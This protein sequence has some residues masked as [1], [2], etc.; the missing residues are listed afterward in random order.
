M[1]SIIKRKV[2]IS[3]LFI[4]LVLMGIFSNQYLPMELYP[5]AELP[6]LS[7]GIS[8][9]GKELDPTYVE[10]KAAI[11]VEGVISS[12]EGVE[13]I[14]TTVDPRQTRIR[15]S[16][17][18]NVNIK[19]TQLQL[20][21]KVLAISKTLPEDEFRVTVS[22]GGAGNAGSNQLMNLRILGDDLDYVRNVV[23]V[24]IVPYFEYIDGVAEVAVSGGR[25][26][27][28]EIIVDPD[29]LKALNITKSTI[30][31][32]ISQNQTDKT[33]S[34]TAYDNDKRY[35]VNV[36][37]EYLATEDL[38]S[39]VVA[40]GPI[41]LKDIAEI[42]FGVKEQETYSR[43]NG[44]EIITCRLS[45][46][47]TANIIDLAGRVREE[48]ERLN[49]EL[50]SK[51]VLIEVESDASEVMSDNINRIIDLAL[52][53]ALLAI[54]VLYL[55]LRKLRIVSVVTFSI[56]I[57]VF[58]SFYFFYLFD[59]TI[60]TLT[61]TGIA[62]AVGMLLDN[63]IVV[64]ENIYRLKAQRLSDDEATARGTKEVWKSIFAATITTVTV[65]LPFLFTDN[66][67]IKL[68]GEHIGISIIATL[69]ISLLVAL[70]LIPMAINYL[71]KRQPGDVNFNNLSIHNRLVQIYRAILKTALR[72]PTRVIIVSLVAL[73]LSIVLSQAFTL[74]VLREPES[75]SFRAVIT[76]YSTSTLQ[77]T[78]E[79]IRTFEEELLNIPEIEQFTSS[80]AADEAILSVKLKE[81][82][83][84]INRKSVVQ[85]R[86]ELYAIAKRLRVPDI[87]IT[88]TASASSSSGGSFTGNTG[89]L[90]MMGI[91]TQQERIVIKGEDFEEM[92]SFGDLLLYQVNELENVS[93]ARLSSSPSNR[94]AKIN[95]DP[96]LMGA[97]NITPRL[98]GTALNAA[99]PQSRTNIMYK[100]GDAEYEIVLQDNDY[101]ESDRRTQVTTLADLRQ[102][103]IQRS[104][105]DPLIELQNVSRINIGPGQGAIRRKNQT[106][107][108]NLTYQFA[109]EIN[110]SKTLLEA[111]RV[112]IDELVQN[113]VAPAGIGIEIIHE[114]SEMGDFT[115]LVIAALLLIYMILAAVFESLIAPIVLMFSI[116]LAAIG[117]LLAL[118]LTS[119]SL[120]NATVYIG[121][122]ILVGIVINN[123]I[124]LIDYTTLLR[125][126]GNRK[127][128]AILLAGMSRLRP[129]LIT[130]ITTIVALV[131][132]ALG[133]G[134]YVSGIG[135]PFAITVIGGLGMSTLLTLV[136]I[137]ALYSGMEDALQRVRSQSAFMKILQAALLLLSLALVF[138]YGDDLLDKVFYTLLVVILVP[139]VTWFLESSLRRAKSDIIPPA[140]ELV[141]TITNLVKVYGRPS[142]FNREWTSGAKIRERLGLKADY[143]HWRDL[144]PLLW[145]L[146]L[147]VFMYYFTFSYQELFLWA[148]I[149]GVVAWSM[150]LSFL[151]IIARFLR[152]RLGDLAGL[153]CDRL[154]DGVRY[155]APLLV[156]W[157]CGDKFYNSG[158]AIFFG[159]F[160]YVAILA[161]HLA[162]KI[163]EENINIDLISGRFRSLKKS[164][165][166]AAVKMPFIGVP[167]KPFKALSSVSMEIRT[168][169]F[170]LLG[171]NGAGKTTLMR[172]ICGIFEQSYGKIFINGIDTQK[173]REEL[174][175]L[176]G[177]LPQEFGTY[178]NLTAGE[179][180][181]YQA[182][183]KGI[184]DARTRANRVDEVLAAVHMFENKDKKIGSFSGGMKQRIGIAQTLL[185]LPRILVVDEPTAG[186]DP[187]ERIRFRNLL[188]ELSRNRI[189]IFSTHIIE[190]IASSCNQ[191]GVIN[192][193]ELK[194][195]GT[196]AD[197][198]NI[199]KDVAWT[200]EV[201][202][203]DFA[204]L[205]SDLLV[206]HHIRQGERIKVRCL[207]ERKP[208]PDAV[209]ILPA[210]EDSYLWLLR[211]V[212]IQGN[213]RVIT[214]AAIDN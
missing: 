14:E 156:L 96:Y 165:Y 194:Y 174:Q 68:L 161:R 188:V 81:D 157:W 45:K 212:K 72:R 210:L 130:A 16:F 187:R 19:Y 56:P 13:E 179:F 15:I 103:P 106:K 134:E 12:L 40:P 189:V 131:P 151:S 24:E 209:N 76:P 105:E 90:R 202:V 8:Y 193:G 53:G 128:R 133:Q 35:F 18:Q 62:L 21:E 114:E 200:F 61:L 31:N 64:M 80:V 42:N 75:D 163:H 60:N 1:N 184:S 191:V 115:F 120:E 203:R 207:C 41:L 176:I 79:M 25:Q 138:L 22:K 149:F 37:A 175:G 51:G 198:A 147:L 97:N 158:G 143:R 92:T 83:E 99:S 69:S 110:E 204:R 162:V 169:M 109:Q 126:Q 29:Q 102:T 140:E 2:L 197:M 91:G 74:N 205:P 27:S 59:I 171:P 93:N 135:A 116:P 170:G 63:S 185:N 137:P 186:L 23:D 71:L 70:L 119:N 10:S 58:S 6:E 167:P 211:N 65:F 159:L 32:L 34:G 144:H 89:L 87:D 118:L 67:Q 206:V 11:P 43:A 180:L 201:P 52:T 44:K 129:I 192:K 124:I 213:E 33:F 77:A 148:F 208:T 39:I 55:F 121:F 168:G 150:T 57:S 9:N 85:V 160:W 195:L 50:Q 101:D 30:T 88:T 117:S 84:E 82:F 132:L 54:F 172:V 86:D 112:E 26:K 214:S 36:T 178:E 173:K 95:F 98:I 4:G 104:A 46:S 113:Q 20:E 139:G 166:R 164:I 181:D 38:G 136:I 3:M 17:S 127:P 5:N 145:L 48:I 108:L 7:V 177:Y 183:L 141:I 190:D 78:D 155:L 123:S 107:D 49:E 94:E 73:F 153:L 199:A 146:P 154:R 182:L 47:P 125:R 100:T 196:P 66:Y 28:I 142:L 111:A 122:I 152:A